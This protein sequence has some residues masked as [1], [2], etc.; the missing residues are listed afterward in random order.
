M[1]SASA[2]SDAQWQAV[3]NALQTEG[4]IAYPTESVWGLGCDP[5]SE[6]A[7]AKIFELKKRDPAKGLILLVSDW[8]QVESLV[9]EDAVV[10]WDR[11]RASWPG[12]VTWVFPAAKSVPSWVC[13]KVGTIALRM[14]AHS[15]AAD[16]VRRFGSPIVSTSANLSGEEAMH[17]LAAV[18]EQFADGVTYLPGECGDLATATPIYCAV[19]GAVIR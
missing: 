9:A 14:S 16:L 6:S 3:L 19:T 5:Y 1:S 12:A 4:V 7:V 13:H 18:R 11:V 15:L 10:D 8:Q 17:D 2:P